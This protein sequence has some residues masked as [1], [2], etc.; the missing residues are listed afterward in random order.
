MEAIMFKRIDHFEIVPSDFERT[1][2]FYIDILGFT[3]RE[4]IPVSA[5]R[6]TEIAFLS[7]GDTTIE[8]ISVKDPAPASEDP[9]PVG[10][11][12]IAIEVDDMDEAVEYLHGKGIEIVW[13]P[14]AI[15]TSKRA[16]IRDPDGLTIEL[17]QW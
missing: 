8:I 11:K 7:L 2:Q 4:R 16:E 12:G 14:V 3:V 9:Y 5:P 17:R 15:G 6:L 1:L 13:G 10:Y